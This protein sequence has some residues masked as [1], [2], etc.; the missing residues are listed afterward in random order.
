[1]SIYEEKEITI[2]QFIRVIRRLPS[3]K[4][5]ED[6]HVGY[7]TQKQHWLGWLRGYKGPGAYGLKIGTAAVFIPDQGN[8]AP[9]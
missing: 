6:P 9:G 8:S 5:I 7:D 2:P 1:M 4:P 3:D